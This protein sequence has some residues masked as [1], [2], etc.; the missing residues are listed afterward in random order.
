MT[1]FDSKAWFWV[2]GDDASQAW[3]SAAAAYVTEWPIDRVTRIA[4]EVELYDVLARANLAARAPSRTF[5]AA[6]VREALVRIDAEATGTAS[7]AAELIVVAEEVGI[8]L[9]NMM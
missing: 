4:N 7:G 1:P 8:K 9:P 3:S 2:I 6:E 5:T